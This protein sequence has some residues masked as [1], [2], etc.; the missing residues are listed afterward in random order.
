MK[1]RLAPERAPHQ[2]EWTERAHQL[3]EELAHVKQRAAFEDPDTGLGNASQFRRDIIRLVARY[4]R[5]GDPFA[6]ALIEPLKVDRPEAELNRDTL[7]AVIEVLLETARI[8]DTVCRLSER[9]FGVALPSTNRA[10]AARYV[11]RL[12]DEIASGAHG[13]RL[14]VV[15]TGGVAEWN[16]AMAKLADIGDAAEADLLAQQERRLAQRP[17]YATP[18]V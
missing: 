8:D 6:I 16:G 13:P 3:E 2:C 9:R 5:H 1:L 4:R 14:L 15:V 11:D 12:G 17:S 18:A 10:G 7:D